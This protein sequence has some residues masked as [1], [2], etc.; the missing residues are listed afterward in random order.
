MEVAKLFA[1]IRDIKGEI[2]T[3]ERH[4]EYLRLSMLP[5]AV[6]YDDDKVQ[7]SYQDPMGAFAEKVSEDEELIRKRLDTLK[8]LNITAERIL[9]KMPTPKYRNLLFLR[10]IE[11]GVRYRYSWSEV[12]INLGYDEQYTRWDLH[13]AAL[14]EAQ[15][16]YDELK[17]QQ[18][19]TSK[20]DIVY[21]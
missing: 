4:E 20:S 17:T 15:T 18:Q 12:A 13:H 10:Y 6:R 19:P 3:L 14:D 21:P 8:E 1:N 2:L 9:D 7:S 5:G 11:G 16:A